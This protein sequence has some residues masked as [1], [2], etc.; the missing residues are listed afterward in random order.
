MKRT[1]NKWQVVLG[2]H[3]IPWMLG[4]GWYSVKIGVLKLTSFPPDGG[5]LLKSNYKG[6]LKE[7]AIFIPIARL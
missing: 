7:F 5:I 2:L 6:F 1:I 3:E 4:K